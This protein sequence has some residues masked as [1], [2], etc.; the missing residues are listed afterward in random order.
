VIDNRERLR[1]Q[2]NPQGI[3]VIFI[4]PELEPA[5]QLRPRKE[6][7]D[8]FMVVT[9]LGTMAFVEDKDHA[10]VTQGREAFLVGLFAL[11]LFCLVIVPGQSLFGI[12]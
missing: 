12:V 9:E 1:S 6:L 5:E 2:S 4:V 7:L 8:G 3:S 11:F 10:L